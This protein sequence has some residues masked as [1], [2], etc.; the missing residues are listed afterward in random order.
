MAWLAQQARDGR[1][2]KN[3]PYAGLTQAQMIA[4]RRLCPER[5][6]D[7]SVEEPGDLGRWRLQSVQC[8][9]L[10]A[11]SL[12]HRLPRLAVAAAAAL[13]SPPRP[14]L[15]AARLSVASP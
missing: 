2:P 8:R 1:A 7:Q 15:V 3:G 9:P 13:Y 10:A 5:A 14:R 6:V 4:D 11:Q 12:G